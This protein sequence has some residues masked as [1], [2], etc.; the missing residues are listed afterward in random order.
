MG[1]A[2]ETAVAVGC[3]GGL[4]VNQAA[5][6]YTRAGFDAVPMNATQGK[7]LFKIQEPGKPV[8]IV[9]SVDFLIKVADLLIDETATEPA[10]YDEITRVFGTKK[11][12]YKVL[13]MGKGIPIFDYL[14][15]GHTVYRIHTKYDRIEDV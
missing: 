2:F 3:N 11:R 13:P 4:K 14:D 9:Q 7:K 12:I 5:I 8:V 1:S 6:T 15:T 10:V